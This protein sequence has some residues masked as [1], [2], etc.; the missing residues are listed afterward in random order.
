MAN[1]MIN[2]I[3]ADIKCGY[4]AIT[5]DGWQ[6]F[7]V[8]KVDEAYE[9]EKQTTNVIAAADEAFAEDMDLQLLE[10]PQ[11]SAAYP[12]DLQKLLRIKQTN[13]FVMRIVCIIQKNKYLI[14]S[15]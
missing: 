14:S 9:N 6:I 5:S 11:S 2:S 1:K 8:L 4:F 12:V 10:Q 13:C 15:L 7:S 3:V